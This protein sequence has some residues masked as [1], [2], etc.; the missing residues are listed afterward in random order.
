M[1]GGP[2]W[3]ACGERGRTFGGQLLLLSSGV[4]P[5]TQKHSGA[6]PNLPNSPFVVVRAAH[7]GLENQEFSQ[8]PA[9][10]LCGL[11]AQG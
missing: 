9:L 1:G 5:L 10:S 2:E 6:S 4:P 11:G 3:V 7:S 8:T